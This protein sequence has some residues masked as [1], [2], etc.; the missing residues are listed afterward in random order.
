MIL[1]NRTFLIAQCGYLLL[2][3]MALLLM[4]GASVVP[5]LLAMVGVWIVVSIVYNSTPWKNNV[6]WWTLLVVLTILSIG[7]VANVHYYTVC[8]GG[9]TQLP[10]LHNPDAFKFYYDALYTVGHSAGVAADVKNHGYGMLISWLWSI[11][12]V[13]IVAPIVL[14]MLFVLI[15]IVMCGGIAYRVLRG[16]TPRNDCWIAT[17]AMLMASSVCYF[18]NSGTLLLKEAG[19]IFSFS[20]IAY[21][22]VSI[23]E[24][25]VHNLRIIKLLV[26]FFVGAVLLTILRF[27]FLIM[28][29]VGIV[30]MTRW[31]K[32]NI[33]LSCILLALCVCC[34]LGESLFMYND[35]SQMPQVATQIV[36]GKGLNGCFFVG[37]EDHESYNLILEGYLGY[38]LWKKTILL[39]MTAAVQYLIPLPWGFCDDIHFGYTLAYAHISYPWYVI[40]GLILYFIVFEMRR[41]S[42]QFQCLVGWGGLMWLVPAFLFA[43]TVSRYALPIL[44]LIIPAA[45][46][47]V[48]KWHELNRLKLKMWCLCYGV[49]LVV[50]LLL[51]Y[52]VQKGVLL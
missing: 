21:V 27:N 42:I 7:I 52:I 17:C 25:K 41:A 37:N 43:G 23:S 38:P 50:G 29:V 11:T 1:T 30:M 9:T 31:K 4:P 8:S 3:L 47:V 13:T 40:G 22:I 35:Y 15:G 51:G 32:R 34:W 26:L 48:A 49:L 46:Y 33:V 44:P 39:P 24:Q 45:V 10:I 5:T 16:Q 18:L 28:V 14:N 2:V 6:G 20:L 12:G 36:G 19:L